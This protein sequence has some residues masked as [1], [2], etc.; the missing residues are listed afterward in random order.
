MKARKIIRR[1]ISALFVIIMIPVIAPFVGLQWSPINCQYQDIDLDTGR[2]R[3]M[4]LIYWVSISQDIKHTAVSLEL[5]EESLN[6]K[7]GNWQRVNTFSPGRKNSP[8]HVFHCALYQVK[9]LEM[10]WVLEGHDDLAR[11]AS[12]KELL[13]LWQKSGCDS[14]VDD[15]LASLVSS[16]STP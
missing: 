16:E 7:G 3:Y 11:K 14:G 8:Y 10:V 5:A 9:Q 4:T 12:A 2:V 15:Y 1:I 13:R 6:A